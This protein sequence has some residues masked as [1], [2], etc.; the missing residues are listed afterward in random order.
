MLPLSYTTRIETHPGAAGTSVVGSRPQAPAMQAAFG[1]H[2]AQQPPQLSGSLVVSTHAAGAP[3]SEP[4]I[5]GKSDSHWHGPAS[6]P[7]AP[8]GVRS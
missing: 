8:P 6:S 5:V 1:L 3:P 2:W 4:Q 7:P